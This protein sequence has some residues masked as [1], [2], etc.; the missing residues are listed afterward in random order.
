MLFVQRI[1]WC[2]PSLKDHS[3][4][5]GGR[6]SG[7]GY[8]RVCGFGYDGIW[9]LKLGMQTFTWETMGKFLVVSAVIVDH[10]L[11]LH[12]SKPVSTCIIKPHILPW[13]IGRWGSTGTL[14]WGKTSIDA[15]VSVRG[16]FRTLRPVGLYAPTLRCPVI[17]IPETAVDPHRLVRRIMKTKWLHVV[18][19]PNWTVVHQQPETVAYICMCIYA[20]LVNQKVNSSTLNIN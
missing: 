1:K 16:C 9:V 7:V 13:G 4:N 14:L 6:I 2:I 15:G 18:E 19:H 12:P 10:E 3:L 20:L 8:G 17:S 11:A 5:T